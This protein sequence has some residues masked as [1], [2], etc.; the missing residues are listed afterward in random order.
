MVYCLS[1]HL[2]LR[3]DVIRK[4]KLLRCGLRTYQ[5][6]S[7]EMG[8]GRLLRIKDLIP[9]LVS[10]KITGS[11]LQESTGDHINDVQLASW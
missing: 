8:P 1:F 3:G 2:N 11:V 4:E 10:Q 6:G 7:K 9:S 5:S